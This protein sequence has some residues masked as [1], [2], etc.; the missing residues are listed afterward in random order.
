MA[1]AAKYFGEFPWCISHG[2]C[3]C[4]GAHFFL[5]KHGFVERRGRC[6]ADVLP[7]NGEGA[8][9]GKP[10]ES[11]ND[12]GATFPLYPADNFQVVAQET[13]FQYETG[14]WNFL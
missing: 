5:T 11:E 3:V 14:G 8:P 1:G 7:Q 4:F 9:H 13:F 6:A 2:V 12:G 10:L